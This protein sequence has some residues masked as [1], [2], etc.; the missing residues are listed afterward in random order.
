V[1]PPLRTPALALALLVAVALFAVAAQTAWANA[2]SQ[3]GRE[4]ASRVC[5]PAPPPPRE[6]LLRQ[7]QWLD[8]T[9]ITE[10]YPA[11]EQW[12]KGRRVHAPGL[13]GLHPVDW[14]YGNWGLAMQGDG[15]GRDGHLYQFA[16]PYGTPW[17]NASGGITSPCAD[18]S[19]TAER[20]AWLALGWRNRSGQVTYPL[21]AGGWTAGPPGRLI[22]IQPAPHFQQV[23]GVA[24]RYWQSVAVDPR[25]IPEGSRIFIPAY[26]NAPNR[27]WFIAQDTGGAIIARHIDVYRPPPQLPF[28]GQSLQN[29]RVYIV[30]PAARPRTLP[31]CRP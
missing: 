11:P 20:P 6:H 25:L 23:A 31:R 29:Q 10:Y 27:G 18:G 28:T 12:F 21:E 3:R 19:W 15:I 22:T 26:C 1:R 13:S 30:P 8:H 2:L 4:A 5:P 14:L 17:V 24:Q 9:L 16:G 7:A